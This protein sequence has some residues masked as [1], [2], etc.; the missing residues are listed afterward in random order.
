MSGFTRKADSMDDIKKFE[1]LLTH[2]IEHNKSHEESYHKWI[3]RAEDAGRK[4]VAR[5]VRKSM[6]HSQEMNRCFEKAIALLKTPS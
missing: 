5:E 2:W 3:Q 4:D 6:E 1:H